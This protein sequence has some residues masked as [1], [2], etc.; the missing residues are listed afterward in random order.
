MATTPKIEDISRILK[1]H[2]PVE[3]GAVLFGSRAS[4]RARPG[5]DWDI[6]VL[7][8]TPLGGEVVQTILDELDELPTLHSFD[9]VDLTTVPEYFRETAVRGAKKILPSVALDTFAKE[10]IMP[11]NTQVDLTAFESALARLGEALAEAETELIRD[12]AIQRF[13]FTFE[14]A[15]KTTMRVEQ[16]SGLE[17]GASPRQVIKVAFK[18]DWI[19]DNELWLTMLND[20]NR[21][22]HAYNRIVAEEI[23]DRLPEYRDALSGLLARL[24]RELEPPEKKNG[25]AF[26]ED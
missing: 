26:V 2:L 4:G 11:A 25:D 5:S 6:G 17:S 3:Y 7:G 16:A 23:F 9:V 8:P 18:A 15:W 21:T 22:S 20:R 24:K 19:D 10:M 12:A 14:L 13:E 1:R